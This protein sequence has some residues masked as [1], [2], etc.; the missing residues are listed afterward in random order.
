MGSAGAW[1]TRPS[2][3][4]PRPV[5]PTAWTWF[6]PP[7]AVSPRG[8]WPCCGAGGAR[9]GW[10]LPPPRAWAHALP[11]SAPGWVRPWCPHTLFLPGF[12]GF[13]PPPPSL[14]V[15]PRN[16]VGE[17]TKQRESLSVWEKSQQ[18]LKIFA[19][20]P[21]FFFFIGYKCLLLNRFRFPFS[22]GVRPG[23]RGAG[24]PG[25]RGPGEPRVLGY[26]GCRGSGRSG[27][28]GCRG[29]W[30]PGVPGF[31][32]FRG[33]GSTGGSGGAGGAGGAGARRAAAARCLEAPGHPGD[34]APRRRF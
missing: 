17:R 11:P 12:S 22:P 26:R 27:V 19:V 34:A 8:A 33:A 1:W 21:R 28:P 16:E 2:A 10:R 20:L 25:F 32:G 9:W 23:G 18:G 30:V 15:A 5:L 31:R 13:A 14:L 29:A 4:R 24:G 3:W 6:C 7:A